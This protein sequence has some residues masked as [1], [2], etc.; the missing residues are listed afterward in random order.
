MLVTSGPRSA[1]GY[2]LRI[3]RVVEQRR[4]V[5]VTAREQTPRLG[6]AVR[7]TF[8]YPYRVITIPKLG[9]AFYVE[10]PGRP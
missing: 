4:R 7:A 9:K 3:V 1:T 2:A 10:T 5:V 8:R 6:Q